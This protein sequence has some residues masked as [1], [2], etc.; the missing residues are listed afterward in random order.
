MTKNGRQGRHI[1]RQGSWFRLDIDGQF[2]RVIV[3]AG[4]GNIACAAVLSLRAVRQ[5][6][7]TCDRVCPENGTR[8]SI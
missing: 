4:R 2:T 7:Q 3:F 1:A 5:S 6:A 8:F